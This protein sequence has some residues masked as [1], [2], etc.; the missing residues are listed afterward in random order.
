MFLTP[1]GSSGTVGLT[2]DASG[3]SSHHEDFR[4]HHDGFY[5]GDGLEP[6]VG[7]ASSPP[8]LVSCKHEVPLFKD[9]RGLVK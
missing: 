9:V 5:S 2:K 1:A 3:A 6:K 8:D 7:Q 4:R